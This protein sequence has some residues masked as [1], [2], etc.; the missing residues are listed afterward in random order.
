MPDQV[1]TGHGEKERQEAP[2]E[3]RSL[4]SEEGEAKE[5]LKKW[6]MRFGDKGS[7][8]RPVQGTKP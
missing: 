3:R 6:F 2:M 8:T 7:F 4:R 1:G 5:E